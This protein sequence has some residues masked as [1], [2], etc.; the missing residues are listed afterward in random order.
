MDIVI[1]FTSNGVKEAGG[2]FV[3]A[4]RTQSELSNLGLSVDLKLVDYNNV[5]FEEINTKAD[6]HHFIGHYSAPET[7][8]SYIRKNSKGIIAI[9]PIYWWTPKVQRVVS[10]NLIKYYYHA[11]PL[12]LQPYTKR[13]KPKTKSFLYA[14]LMLPNSPKEGNLVEKYFPLNKNIL[15][16]PVPNAVD[17]LPRQLPGYLGDL[18]LPD[19]Y[20]LCTGMFNQR[21]N[22]LSLIRALKGTGL[23]LVFL[24]KPSFGS[25]SYIAYYDQCRKESGGSATFIGYSEHRSPLW[26]KVFSN[27]RAFAIPS[28]CE[29]PSLAALESAL[30]GTPL[31][32]TTIG[33]TREYFGNYA[34]Y[35]DPLDLK[36]IRIAVE[37]AADSECRLDLADHIRSHYYWNKTAILTKMAY[38]ATVTRAKIDFDNYIAASEGMWFK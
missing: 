35:C 34:N 8:L 25:N 4:T 2:A 5:N 7:L 22:Q 10:S 37:K 15:I 16:C 38:I 32:I 33:S 19:N 20:I 26:Y 9:S 18:T 29:T 30:F 28:A 11:F 24:G 14:D 23:K 36:S 3:Q 12:Y 6:V 13:I 17:P 1:Y 27:A 21:K 31:A